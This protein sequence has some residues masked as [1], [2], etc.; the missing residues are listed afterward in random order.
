MHIA[1]RLI[2]IITVVALAAPVLQ[3]QQQSSGTVD[4]TDVMRAYVH[5]IPAGSRVRLTLDDGTRVR[6]VLM[7]VQGDVLVLRERKRHPEPPRHIAIEHIADV[8]LDKNGGGIAKAVAIGASVGAA[9]ALSVIAI[10]AAALG[11]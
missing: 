11:D 3:A 7:L 10:L 6:G 4:G 1:T 2:S 9:A 5:R 8:E